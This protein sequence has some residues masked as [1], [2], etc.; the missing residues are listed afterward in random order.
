[1][2]VEGGRNGTVEGEEMEEEGEDGK[3]RNTKEE[4]RRNGSVTGEGKQWEK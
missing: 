3:I 2:G 1:M 4:M